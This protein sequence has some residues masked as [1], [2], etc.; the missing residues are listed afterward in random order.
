MAEKAGV[1]VNADKASTESTLRNPP[2]AIHPEDGSGGARLSGGG[3]EARQALIS[4]DRKQ[5]SRS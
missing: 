3:A 1:T 4:V 2:S 5:R